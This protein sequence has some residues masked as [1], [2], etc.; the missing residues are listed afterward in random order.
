M[1]ADFDLQ[2]NLFFDAPLQGYTSDVAAA[3]AANAVV[4]YNALAGWAHVI[5]EIHWSYTGTVTSGNLQ[6]ADGSDVIFNVDISAAGEG[7]FRFSRP[8]TG[9][10]GQAMTVTLANGG[11][12]VAGKITVGHDMQSNTFLVGLNYANGLDNSQYIAPEMWWL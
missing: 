2:T 10:L 3:T 6:V 8:R 5:Y 11:T 1:P 4:T 7:T 9:T 12:G